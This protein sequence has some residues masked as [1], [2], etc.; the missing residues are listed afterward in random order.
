M[1]AFVAIQNALRPFGYP[2]VPGRYTGKENRF[3]EYNYAHRGGGNFGDN[4]PACNVASVQVHLFLP[5]KEDFRGIMNSVQGALDEAEF[6]W[7]DVTVRDEYDDIEAEENGTRQRLD[8]VR[9]IIFECEYEE[10]IG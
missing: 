5:L 9:H 7:P 6:T 2:C 10:T 8:G 4:K 3:F 1:D